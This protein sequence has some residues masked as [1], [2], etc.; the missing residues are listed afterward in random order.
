M[1]EED[2]E[3]IANLDL[4]TKNDTVNDPGK[5]GIKIIRQARDKHF[6]EIEGISKRRAERQTCKLEWEKERPHINYNSGNKDACKTSQTKNASA[7]TKGDASST[8]IYRYEILQKYSIDR[9]K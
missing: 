1:C 2:K 7:I 6:R 8:C 3:S 9:R 5:R 4:R